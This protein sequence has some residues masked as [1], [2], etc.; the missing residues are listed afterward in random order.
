MPETMTKQKLDALKVVLSQSGPD[1]LYKVM[2]DAGYPYAKL[3]EGVALGDSL[4]GAAAIN[5]MELTASQAGS[6]ITPEKLKIIRSDMA[7]AYLS[8]LALQLKDG[9]SI[10]R[11]ID[12]DEAWGFHNA[13]FAANQLDQ[14][15]WTLNSVFNA[16]D[17]SNRQAYWQLVKESAG[18]KFAESELAFQTHRM[19]ALVSVIGSTQDQ[20]SAKSWLARVEH[21]ST[22]GAVVQMI[23]DNVG[24]AFSD[25]SFRDLFN[26]APAAEDVGPVPEHP[27][28]DAEAAAA[29]EDPAPINPAQAG[30]DPT[31]GVGHGGGTGFGSSEVVNGQN[32]GLASPA[33]LPQGRIDIGPL[34]RPLGPLG[35]TQADLCNGPSIGTRG[36]EQYNPNNRQN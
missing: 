5:F 1:A 17:P 25:F 34:E 31:M 16:M 22:A 29:P 19:M 32:I 20:Q 7:Q 30:P 24:K 33:E 6:P 13:I 14:D 23:A 11:D 8:T 9:G 36:C 3:A 26:I 12:A 2:A 18:N 28:G 35:P 15:S 21:Y 4:S 10:T 27:V